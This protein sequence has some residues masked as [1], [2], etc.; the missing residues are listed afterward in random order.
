MLNGRKPLPFTAQVIDLLLIELTNW[1]WSWRSMLIIATLA[2]LLSI[3]ALGV[4]ARDAGPDALR[5]VLTGNVVMALMF[6]IMGNVQ[7]HFNFMRVMGGLDFFATLPVSKFALILAVVLGFLLLSMP[8]IVVTAGMGALILDIPL[9]L[10]PLVILVIPACAVP[11]AGIGAII[12]IRGR[13]PQESGAINLLVTLVLAGLGPV[14][15]PPERL[16]EWLVLIGRLSPATYAA[17]AL[18]ETLLGPVSAVLITDLLALTGFGLVSFW[19]VGRF[20][21]WR[22]R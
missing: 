21:D 22:Q 3:L 12:G 1:R 9:A 17:S 18:R 13:N 20:L 10:S 4:F 6:G 7:S 15:I 14:V 19:L 5:Y 11:L 16:P 8:S 2:P